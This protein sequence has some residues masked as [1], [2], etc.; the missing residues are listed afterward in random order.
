[1]KNQFFPGPRVLIAAPVSDRHSHLLN[2]WI[3]HLE[4][5]DYPNIDVCLVDN[6][7][8]NDDYFNKIKTL[9]V[10]GR[11][12][13]TWKHQW[14]SQK[15]HP[16]QMLADVREDIRKYF[17]EHKE[18]NFLFWLDQDIFIPKWG[19]QRLLSYN[20]DLVGFYVHVF[21]K[22]Q[23]KPCVL[24]SGEVLL[25]GGLDYYTF[26]EIDAYKR[27]VAKYKAKKLTKEEKLLV[28]FLIKE[29]FK[30]QLFETYWVGLG[31]LM[32]SRKVSEIVPFLTHPTLIWGED[33]WYAA[34]VNDKGFRVFCDTTIRPEH[35]NC[36]WSAVIKKS[37]QVMNFYVAQGPVKSKEA[38]IIDRSKK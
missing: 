10:K 14:D 4:Q 12:V 6:T 19:V 22:G 23:H 34:A 38:V 28:P 26:S 25:G 8:E 20:R 2:K 31:C 21:P 3:K 30:P 29:R 13:I 15:R 16:L 37:P 11:N 17:I 33:L 36:D 18:Y 35:F 7:K 24:K 32:C 9:K 27:F 1:M 5:L